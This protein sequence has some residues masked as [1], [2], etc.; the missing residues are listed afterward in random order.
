MP[1][2]VDGNHIHEKHGIKHVDVEGASV[3]GC[4]NENINGI[5]H[6][7]NTEER[8]PNSSTEKSTAKQNKRYWQIGSIVSCFIA[9][10]FAGG[11]GNSYGVMYT[12]M[13]EPLGTTEWELSWI[14]SLMGACTGFVCILGTF[15]V[16]SLGS[17][18]TTV[19]G[20]V[21]T[22]LGYAIGSQMNNIYLLY[23]TLGILPGTGV[24]IAYTAGMVH[25]NRQFSKW[26]PVAVGI[27]VTGIAI[28]MLSW[29][30]LSAA[31]AENMG[32]RG[33]F[34]IYGALTMHFL[35]CALLI[36]PRT[37]KDVHY[38]KVS[39]R[40]IMFNCFKIYRLPGALAF[41]I[42]QLTFGF[43]YY[44][45][46]TFLPDYLTTSFSMTSAEAAL[47]VSSSGYGSIFGRVIFCAIAMVK[48]NGICYILFFSSC[49]CGISNMIVPLCD[50]P[51]T[52]HIN[53]AVNGLAIGGW[54]GV[55]SVVF[56][57]LFGL[58]NLSK[59]FGMNM[60]CQGFG[61]LAGPPIQ[62]YL[63]TIL[64]KDITFYSAGTSFLVTTMLVMVA[65]WQKK[66]ASGT[67][68][69]LTIVVVGVDNKGF[70]QDKV[71]N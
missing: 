60:V 67:S 20:A 32:W 52:H 22:V 51:T 64:W 34:L 13:K 33:T 63:A 4:K 31:V 50:G 45:F 42:A 7:K 39:L 65:F 3:S 15:C 21:L 47:I 12:Y 6:D 18:V 10:Y 25:V 46:A 14:G 70:S 68:S 8:H 11:L 59:T 29:P 35:P 24:S 66:R 2:T 19:I 53:S 69:V 26:R 56:V 9:N 38:P 37:V 28:G 5:Y 40:E 61:A 57:E 43:S 27:A 49:M 30:P 54:M 23:F 1:L 44:T 41:S 36:P 71:L 48:K 17:R 16:D 55:L 62:S 58:D